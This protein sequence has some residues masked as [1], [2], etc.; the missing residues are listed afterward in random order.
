M[1]N[2]RSWS[3]KN[4]SKNNHFFTKSIN[5]EIYI[6]AVICHLKIQHIMSFKCGEKHM[7]KCAFEDR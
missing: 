3:G 2:T 5:V 7:K 4:V 1:K 6:Q